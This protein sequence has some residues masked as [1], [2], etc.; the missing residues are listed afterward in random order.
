VITNWISVDVFIQT[1]KQFLI[2]I[3]PP[4][5]ANAN[6]MIDLLQ[7]LYIDLNNPLLFWTNENKI[8]SKIR[9]QFGEDSNRI[10]YQDY[11]IKEL[12]I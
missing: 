6:T 4:H 5:E 8:N 3:V 2:D 1:Y 11:L 10:L 7:L 9:I 12:I